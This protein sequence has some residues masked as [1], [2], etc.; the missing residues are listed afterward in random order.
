MPDWFPVVSVVVGLFCAVVPV[1]V[2]FGATAGCVVWLAVC[3]L[4]VTVGV[5]AMLPD[6]ESGSDE[7]G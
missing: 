5:A 4:V 3:G 7:V 6:D 1:W 2:L